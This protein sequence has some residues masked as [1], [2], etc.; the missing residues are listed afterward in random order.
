[1]P[2]ERL[3][4]RLTESVDGSACVWLS[5]PAGSGKSSLVSSYL[6]R[7]RTKALWYNFDEG[8]TD[9]ATFFYYLSTAARGLLGETEAVLPHLA[10]EYLPKINIFARRY[11]EKLYS[12]L[13]QP[14]TLV[15]ENCQEIPADSVIFEILAIAI[16]VLPEKMNLLFTSRNELPPQISHLK[17]RYS[18]EAIHSSELRFNREEAFE[19]AK[20]QLGE[21]ESSQLATLIDQIDGW[22]SGLVLLIDQL[23]SGK[24]AIQLGDA[25]A[26]LTDTTFSYFA[27]EYFASAGEEVREFLLRTSWLPLMT[28]SM[29]M[30]LSG[31]SDAESIL[32]GLVNSNFFIERHRTGETVYRFHALFRQFLQ[33]ESVKHYSSETLDE[34][35]KLASRLLVKQGMSEL[36]FD[37]MADT[38]DWSY[39]LRETLRLAPMFVSQGR[40]Q[41]LHKWLNKAPESFVEQSPWAGYWFAKSILYRDIKLARNHLEKSFNLF[42]NRQDYHGQLVSWI[43]IVETFFYE[44][45]DVHQLDNW[46]ATFFDMY[47]PDVSIG[48]S[49]LEAG[50]ALGVFT[51]MFLRCPEHEKMGY[52]EDRLLGMLQQSLPLSIKLN[53]ANTLLFHFIWYS[54]NRGKATLVIESMPANIDTSSEIEPL[55]QTMW[56]AHQASYKCWFSDKR[57]DIYGDIDRT[58]ELARHHGIHIADSLALIVGACTAF[59][60]GQ[61]EKGHEFIRG[62][63]DALNSNRRVDLSLYHQ[64]MAW[65]Y[66]LDKKWSDALAH[67]SASLEI[68]EQCGVPSTQVRSFLGM[69]QISMSL[70]EAS[71]AWRYLARA[72]HM[73]RAMKSRNNLYIAYLISAQ[74]AFEKRKYRRC[75]VL[76][77]RALS[78]GNHQGYLNVVWLRREQLAD[79]FVFALEQ[80][81]EPEF[82]TRVVNSLKLE[83]VKAPVHIE[84]WPWKTR[85]YTLGRFEIVGGGGGAPAKIQGRPMDLLRNLISLGGRNVR[86]DH[87]LENFCAEEDDKAQQLFHTNL[88]RLRKLLGGEE[89][90]IW[91]SGQVSLNERLCWV[92]A[93]AFDAL[94]MDTRH[95]YFQM[96]RMQRAWELYRGRFFREEL[97]D[98]SAVALQERLHNKFIRLCVDYGKLLESKGLSVEVVDMFWE[99]TK[100]DPLAEPLYQALIEC[101]VAQ[102]RRSEAAA[103]L[104]RYSQ[105]VRS[106]IGC[107]PSPKLQTLLDA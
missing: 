13:P 51:A 62:A 45:G 68:M 25:L 67:V 58:L 49:D 19:F 12:I 57:Q 46:L 40:H 34:I 103:L 32:T 63:R 4:K 26:E 75:K 5:G 36:A 59:M 64:Y 20:T 100:V 71:N 6:K 94:T 8:D 73:A 92:D 38:Q 96:S 43:G 42:T 33:N 69:A 15:F 52:W 17:M 47:K 60:D 37:L 39:L 2:R 95:D 24:S 7:R 90:V 27:S 99:S 29:A 31:Y 88:Y 80:G 76:L 104:Q 79:L 84:E 35:R 66:W 30:E 10:P 107:D 85:I 86:V 77:R 97:E 89:T 23:K 98:F 9:A 21:V 93:W 72:K 28:S 1:M 106:E 14:T 105:L 16:S 18:I 3:F 70:G 83:P 11:F 74:F 61:L 22:A 55:L 81:I 102:G 54:G 56:I 50:V 48:N 87:L 44:W 53:I 91:E 101:Y 65:E 82:V 78:V 41:T